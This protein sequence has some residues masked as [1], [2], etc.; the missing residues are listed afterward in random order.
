MYKLID[1]TEL[2]TAKETDQI[3][4]DL[5]DLNTE[6]KSNL[7]AA[8]NEITVSGNIDRAARQQIAQVRQSL[9]DETT[10]AMSQELVLNN[11]IDAEIE[12]A[13][14]VE[15]QLTDAIDTKADVS[16]LDDYYTKTETDNLLHDKAD[17]SALDD[18]YTKTE[19]DNLLHD[20]ADSNNVYTKSE[21]NTLLAAK[22][23]STDVYDKNAVD[24]LLN[25]KADSSQLNNFYTKSDTY[26][27]QE[28]N[29][30]LSAKA[31]STALANYYS[32]TETDTL[33]S[34]KADSSSVYTKSE[35]YDKN[36]VDTLLNAKAD[37]IDTYT[38]SET[39][40]AITGLISDGTV[41]ADKTWSSS[42]ISGELATKTS[43]PKGFVYIQLKGKSSP[44]D[45]GMQPATGC[46]WV[47]I[48]A[49]YASFPYIKIGS[50]TTQIGHNAYHR[51][52]MSHTHGMQNHTH[53]H[54]HIAY[55]GCY[56]SNNEAGGYGLGLQSGFKNRVMVSAPSNVGTSWDA[57]GPSNNTTEAASN[58]NTSYD[59]NSSQQTVEVNATYAVVWEVQ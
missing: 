47:D 56:S 59:G 12:R 48:T 13:A 27:K 43:Y 29:T 31:D 49:D 38:K 1:G 44:A 32:K 18:Y 25:T 6:D 45:M 10:R 17:A 8:V 55:M 50:G 11:K 42:K 16:A 24:T 40:S 30:L 20:K 23:N 52:T 41:Q 58:S 19:A 35:V 39:D 51:H 21:S 36:A 57:T 46:S 14:G 22:A 7:V 3:T 28:T 33:L 34:A 15:S 5:A 26:S 53:G 2:Y 54:S 4:G 9:N 37:S